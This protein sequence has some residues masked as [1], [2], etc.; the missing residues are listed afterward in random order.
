MT[1]ETKQKMKKGTWLRRMTRDDFRALGIGKSA[2]VLVQKF[3]EV[4]TLRAQASKMSSIIPNSRF[5]VNYRKG[6]E[7]AVVT[8]HEEK[9][10]DA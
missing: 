7:F 2:R 3:E 8:R 9:G 10:G 4:E 5:S 1:E 6:D